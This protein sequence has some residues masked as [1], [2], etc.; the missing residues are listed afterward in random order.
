MGV[1]G[2]QFRVQFRGGGGFTYVIMLPKSNYPPPLVIRIKMCYF[3]PRPSI[4]L[5]ELLGI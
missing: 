1:T 4:R 3:Y 5:G 2:E